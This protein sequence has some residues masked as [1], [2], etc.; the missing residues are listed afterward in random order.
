[1]GRETTPGVLA[2]TMRPVLTSDSAISWT[3][4]LHPFA[5]ELPAD[6]DWVHFGRF[7]KPGSSVE[8]LAQRWTWADERNAQLD[9]AIPERFVRNAVIKNANNDLA[10]AA[11][12]ECTVTIDGLHSQIVG[13][14]FRDEEGWK[15]RGYSIPILFPQIGDWSWQQIADLRRERNMTR[16]RAV[17]REIEDEAAAE[18]AGGD[19]EGAARHAYERHLASAVPGLSNIGSVARDTTIGFIIGGTA[20]L[21]T[22]G[23]AGPGGPLAGAAIGVAPGTIAGIRNISRQRRSR[24]WMTVRNTIA[25]QNRP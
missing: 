21:L 17:L 3:A 9:Q 7:T 8:Q 18:A 10:I 4:T 24:G 20:G 23:I 6:A 14:R 15:L 11:A 19:L 25:Q 1:M 13:Q 5:D 12:T 22:M 16:F 2:E